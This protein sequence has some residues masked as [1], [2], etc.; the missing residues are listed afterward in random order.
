M[1]IK[2]ISIQISIQ[3]K[4]GSTW[5]PLGRSYLKKMREIVIINPNIAAT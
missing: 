2:C 3:I 4:K 1:L 5:D